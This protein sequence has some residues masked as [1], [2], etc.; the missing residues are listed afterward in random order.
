M[1]SAFSGLDLALRALRSQQALVDVANNNIANANTPGYS[2][3]TATLR[4]APPF[5]A[6]GLSA[7]SE[8]GQIGSGVDIASIQRARDTFT[9][10]Q[11]R[12]EL[13]SQD[14]ANAR[15]DGLKQLEAI[16][17]EPSPDGLS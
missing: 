2:R 3:Q 8:P 15:S 16:F 12:A 9:D 4:A 5:P 14:R 6:P 7:G 13:A 17:N 1:T 11:L 10:Y